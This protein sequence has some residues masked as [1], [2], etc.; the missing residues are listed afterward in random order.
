MTNWER[1]C[2]W[3]TRHGIDGLTMPDDDGLFPR[4]DL[5]CV[6]PFF[7]VYWKG[8]PPVPG[9]WDALGK[10]QW[11]RFMRADQALDFV[12]A[13]YPPTSDPDGFEDAVK[14]AL[15]SW[16]VPVDP[17]LAERTHILARRV[18]AIRVDLR[19]EKRS[20]PE[21]GEARLSW[22]RRPDKFPD[23]MRRA[24]PGFDPV[25]TPEN[26]RAGLTRY[27]AEGWEIDDN[28]ALVCTTD[29]TPWGPST[30]RIPYRLHD[31]PRRLMLGAS[32]QAR[33]V[34]LRES[35]VP[36]GA[37]EFEEGWFPPGRNL[38]A[39]FSALGGW[40]HEDA[41]VLSRSAAEKLTA[42]LI[43]RKRVLVPA[44]AYYRLEVS[45]KGQRVN[46]GQLLARAY[47]DLYALGWRKHEAEAYGAQDGWLEIALPGAESPAD[48]ELIEDVHIRTLRTPNWRASLLFKI[49][50]V[51][52]LGV[53]D[54]LATRHGIKG[55]VS[56]VREDKDM[57]D[58]PDGK[59]EIVLSPVGLVRRG[60][61]G[62]FR[63]A[64]AN[65]STDGLPHCGTVFVMRQPQDALPRCRVRGPGA[66]KIRGQR[67]GEMEFWALMAHGAGKIAE[68]LLSVRRSTSAM[69][70]GVHKPSV[71]YPFN[72]MAAEEAISS[73]QDHRVLATQALNRYIGLLGAKFESG[74]LQAPQ[75]D[76]NGCFVPTFSND[77]HRLNPRRLAEL[78]ELLDHLG[79]AQWF[80]Q[81]AGA[82]VVELWRPVELELPA[83]NGPGG[84]RF[85]FEVFGILPPWLRPAG[86]RWT[87]PLT[88]EYQK[89]LHSAAFGWSGRVAL[90]LEEAIRSCLNVAFDERLGAG[91]FLRRQILGRRLTRS[92]RAVIVPNPELR[93]DQIG[94]PRFVLDE[95]FCGLREANRQLLLVNRNPTLH[96][97]GLLA[98]RP[99]ADE[100]N[101]PVFQLPLGILRVMGADFDGD[102]VSVVALETPDALEEALRLLPGSAALRIDP[103]RI[104]RPAFPL[105]RELS[106]VERELELAKR[107][108]LS[109]D[110][111]C[112]LHQQ[113][114][115]DLLSEAGDGWSAA[116]E[117]S[118]AQMVLWKGLSEREWLDRA[119]QEME[120]VYAVRQKGQLGGILRRQLYR[121]E[122]VDHQKFQEAVAALQAVTER[123]TQEAL[124]VKTHPSV[125]E[126]PVDQSSGS[127]PRKAKRAF[128]PST[129]FE[130][131]SSAK[132][133]LATLDDPT[134]GPLDPEAVCA[135]LKPAK[136]PTGLLAWLARPTLKTLIKLMVDPSANQPPPRHEEDPR[137]AWFLA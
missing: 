89:L 45:M 52:P 37:V 68:E 1:Y 88:K 58:H 108:D 2:D 119:H 122:F 8:Q 136:Q 48:G 63:E 30:S 47:L 23:S 69:L 22:T 6:L 75:R 17:P 54:K 83:A 13:F 16:L 91:A 43:L 11:A 80:M 66:G 57:P 92:A 78:R 32:L 130:D 59:A 76:P 35:D 87:H 62:Q 90:P 4:G 46:R 97:R 121:Q 135:K 99:V 29:A 3:L 137:I 25:H 33:A 116:Q 42:D 124:S 95:L 28:G 82:V 117:A 105:L 50:A 21:G 41:I 65:D 24:I 7:R 86:D 9:K 77:V 106:A 101:R 19:K 114:L 34:P 102:Q 12:A 109:Q 36:M 18:E 20:D 14:L 127:R 94:V 100:H 96:W 51:L 64:A 26:E 93:I 107:A 38:R 98:L 73:H 55:V 128:S 126:R 103:F 53:G 72:W 112:R 110:E 67:Y 85:R 49:R 40:T 39:V 81:R 120:K 104:D 5:V 113:L 61:M 115:R 132:T 27:L 134:L 79:D 71:P 118:G 125:G 60:A 70:N 56:Q 84:A 133:F 31:A 10:D 129:F 15:K 131:P 111:W 44:L 74:V 123:L